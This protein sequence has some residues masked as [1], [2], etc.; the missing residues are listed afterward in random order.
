VTISTVLK[1]SVGFA[2]FGVTPLGLA[3][4]GS[5]SDIVLDF[6]AC[7]MIGKRINPMEKGKRRQGI[8]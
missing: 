8:K 5:E 3:K 1:P 4:A 6:L 7:I 2:K